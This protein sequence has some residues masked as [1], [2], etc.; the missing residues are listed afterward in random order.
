[1][2]IKVRCF[3]NTSAMFEPYTPGDLLVPCHTITFDESVLKDAMG[4]L[5]SAYRIGNRMGADA[6]GAEWPHTVRSMS[7]GDVVLVEVNEK[8]FEWAA[9][10]TFGFKTIDAPESVLA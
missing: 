5:E 3:Q 7:V 4:V 10:D 6:V 9:V 1:M 2:D 8:A